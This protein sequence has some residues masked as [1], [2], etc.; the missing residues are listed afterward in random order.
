[1]IRWVTPGCHL[2][3]AGAF[4]WTWCLPEAFPVSFVVSLIQI[5][6]MELSLLF[7]ILILVLGV[8][9]IP[10][11]QAGPGIRILLPFVFCLMIL[12]GPLVACFRT[13][14][15]VPLVVFAVLLTVRCV[16]LSRERRRGELTGEFLTGWLWAVGAL[17]VMSVLVDLLPVPPGG[18]TPDFVAS[19]GLDPP[20]GGPDSA[21]GSTTPFAMFDQPRGSIAWGF[22]YFTLLALGELVVPLIPGGQEKL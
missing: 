21:R 11:T 9:R 1:M 7:G 15:L 4:L 13:G 20:G 19:L 18:F 5:A 10:P 14:T 6:W 17:M 2:I 3:T 8:W 22:G 12:C 16:P